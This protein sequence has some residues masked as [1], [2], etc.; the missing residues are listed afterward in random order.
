VLNEKD[1]RELSKLRFENAIN[2]SSVIENT[3]FPHG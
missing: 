2:A 1:C 3:S